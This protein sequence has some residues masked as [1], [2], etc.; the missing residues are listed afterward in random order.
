MK[1]LYKNFLSLKGRTNCNSLTLNSDNQ[2]KQCP[3][4][5]YLIEQ[6]LNSLNAFFRRSNSRKLSSIR[7]SNKLQFIDT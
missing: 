7:G 2:L 3:D 5:I 1:K 6:I 4:P